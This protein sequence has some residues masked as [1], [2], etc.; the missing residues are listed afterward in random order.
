MD[1]ND[2]FSN[3]TWDVTVTCISA[4]NLLGRIAHVHVGT[5]NFTKQW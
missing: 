2:N 5:T 3:W 1:Y 4:M